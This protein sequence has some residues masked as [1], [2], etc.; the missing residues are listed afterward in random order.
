MALAEHEVTQQEA[1]QVT[2]RLTE[3]QAAKLRQAAAAKGQSVEEFITS[4]SVRAADAPHVGLVLPVGRDPLDSLFRLLEFEPELD[5]LMER[6]HAERR[7]Q[8]EAARQ[9]AEET[10]RP[11]LFTSYDG[12]TREVGALPAN[13]G[14]ATAL[15]N[16]KAAEKIWGT[17][18]EEAACRAMQKGI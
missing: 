18:E 9:T 3:A 13:L 7:L 16:E 11:V 1:V 12:T 14:R 15:A 6:I 5:A 4:T 10:D 17:A 8:E 2:V